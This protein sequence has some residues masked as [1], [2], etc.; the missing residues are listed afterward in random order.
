MKSEYEL[1][2][3]IISVKFFHNTFRKKRVA[4]DCFVIFWSKYCSSTKSRNV[5]LTHSLNI[6]V[7]ANIY[8]TENVL[9]LF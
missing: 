6:I 4:F 7:N 2:Y 1:V 3:Q 8:V 5:Y 9:F